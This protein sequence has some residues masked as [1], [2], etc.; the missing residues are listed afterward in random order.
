MR[1]M[2]LIV[3]LALGLTLP[4]LAFA[5][6]KTIK[7][8][9]LPITHSIP[10]FILKD[11]VESNSA[12]KIAI[13]LV[14]YGTWPELVDALVSER[15]DGA[16][17]FIEFA[18]KA[19][20]QGIDLKAV[21][22]AHRDGATMIVAKDINGIA[23]LK[24]KTVAIPEPFSTMNILVHLALQKE[25]IAYS[26]LNIV[27]LPPPEMPVALAEKRVSGYIVADPFAAI[28]LVNGNGKILFTADQIWKN[29]VCCGLILHNNFIKNSKA[30]ALELAQGYRKAGAAANKKDERV[31]SLAS[32]YMT[33]NQEIIKISLNTISYD[34]LDLKQ[35]DY[36]Q[37]TKYLAEFNL[38]KDSP[39]YADFVEN[40]LK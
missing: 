14:K 34:D 29:S 18:M 6:V 3:L 25:G 4:T 15:V 23:D 40:S 30:A 26:D 21:S 27:V 16:T 2:A 19:K 8:A 7:L 33:A 17:M 1:K 5:Q 35:E 13:E 24:G 32:K 38:L 12:S 10:L 20:E 28:S 9:Y 31:Y 11:D 37:L 39:T 36:D 22:L